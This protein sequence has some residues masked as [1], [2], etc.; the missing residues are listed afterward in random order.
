MP[1]GLL[2]ITMGVEFPGC[3]RGL[4][5]QPGWEWVGNGEHQSGFVPRCPWGP[6]REVSGPAPPPWGSQEHVERHLRSPAL[7]QQHNCFPW[8]VAEP[9]N[10]RPGWGLP[11]WRCFKPTWARHLRQVTLP[12]QG[13]GLGDPQS[14]FHPERFCDSETGC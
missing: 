14:S 10:S 3:E 7:P 13:V 1:P 6:R 8:R 9:W 12:W 2:N 5:R 11:L 4:R